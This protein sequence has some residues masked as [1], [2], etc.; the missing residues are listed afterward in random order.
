MLH[1]N[2]FSVKAKT[3]IFYLYQSPDYFSRQLY[4]TFHI[5][6]RKTGLVLSCGDNL[7]EMPKPVFSKEKT[8]KKKKQKKK[9]KTGKIFQNVSC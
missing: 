2:R 9:K 1:V 6:S 5:F 4:D 7:H 3:L 8:K